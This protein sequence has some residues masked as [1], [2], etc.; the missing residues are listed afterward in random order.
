L[1]VTEV[2]FLEEI[3]KSLQDKVQTEVTKEKAEVGN[4]KTGY[5]KMIDMAWTVCQVEDHQLLCQALEWRSVERGQ[6][7]INLEWG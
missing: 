6:T 4:N 2:A 1:S 7:M 3:W 5:M